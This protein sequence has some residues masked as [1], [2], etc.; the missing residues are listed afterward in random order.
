M[1]KPFA[2][3]VRGAGIR[4]RRRRFLSP[5]FELVRP[6]APLFT[7]R[8]VA[9]AVLLGAASTSFGGAW[10]QN[11][12]AEMAPAAPLVGAIPGPPAPAAIP[13]AAS[14]NILILALD[15]L[16]ISEPEPVFVPD[17]V[18]P[19]LATENGI[20]PLVPRVP[21]PLNPETAPDRAPAIAP[22]PIAPVAPPAIAPAPAAPR[23]DAPIVPAPTASY[24]ADLR[25]KWLVNAQQNNRQPERF[26][27]TPE[28][29]GTRARPEIPALPTLP[30]A[31]ART[32]LPPMAA[33]NPP[34]NAQITAVAL[35]RAL[36]GRGFTDVLTVAPD[37]AAIIRAVGE[38]RLTMRVIDN[39]KRAIATLSQP[40]K[41]ADPVALDLATRNAIRVGQALGYRAVVVVHQGAPV[42]LENGF[43]A[44]FT[45]VLA[46]TNR[47][48][49]EP[50]A[51]DETGADENLLRENGATAAV[52]LL[53]KSLRDWTIT[54][55]ADK[56]T[57]AAKHLEAARAAFAASNVAL[58][59]DE[60]NQSIALD[61]QRADAF[62]L[63][64]DILRAT[65][66]Q[67]AATAYR[68]AVELNAR[69]GATWAKIAAAYAYAP[70]PDWP[71]SLDAASRAL[72]SGY[73]NASLR[74]AMATAQ[75]GRAALFRRAGREERA[76]DAEFEARAHLDRAL[77][78]SPD[79]PS[80]IRLLARALVSSRRF[81]E[82][83]RTLDR[84]APRYP[85]DLELQTQYAAALG[86]QA[87]REEDA[88]VAYGRVWK[89]ASLARVDV[90][91]ALYRTLAEGFD[92]RM[93]NLGKTAAQL[94]TGVANGAFPR[95]SAF[96]QLSKLKEDAAL[97]ETALGT[98]RPAGNV[99]EE[100]VAS[101]VFAADLMNQSL[102]AH[103]TFLETG[104]ELY[105]A[106][107]L[108]LY[109]Q[110]IAR[111]N[112]ARTT[113]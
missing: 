47:E 11:L 37:S 100:A 62:V 90:D 25:V 17:P 14:I 86:G 94:T 29:G 52:T 15:D 16:V 44:G 111:L 45:L 84:I 80:A 96:L 104:Q 46:D 113:R 66:P 19:N 35:R 110:A 82:A 55:A 21:R 43:G 23:R 12:T 101:R 61:P 75:Y 109:R 28:F 69:D 77:E 1:K 13:N 22:A 40:N 63:Q 79:D 74:V 95:E 36:L 105:R 20:V 3:D 88:F 49:G 85:R 6:G 33:P 42:K 98:M 71:R 58:A 65:D 10:A 5:Q 73:D 48:T 31:P 9:A 89:L 4:F 53:D 72:A 64:G 108:E 76:E 26:L 70:T 93:A 8:F 106:R 50:I 99:S 34:G 103:Q 51:V 92:V 67:G 59:Q 54:S 112:A 2:M 38:R 32:E 60:V 24:G 56:V 18:L 83:L 30:A 107:G 7:S 41:A 87:G 81:D 102:E 91:A 27:P 57:L 78:L 39:I 68:R 97:A